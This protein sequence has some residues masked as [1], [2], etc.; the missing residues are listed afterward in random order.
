ME[1]LIRMINAFAWILVF[2]CPIRLILKFYL[3]YTYTGSLEETEDKLKGVQTV[4]NRG[5]V[6]LLVIFIVSLVYL[7]VK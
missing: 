3:H 5:I 1:T 7:I 2:A 4:Y 6:K